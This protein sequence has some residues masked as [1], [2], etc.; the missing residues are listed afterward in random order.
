MGGKKQINVRINVFGLLLISLC[1]TAD[2]F[3]SLLM[4]GKKRKELKITYASA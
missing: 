3:L 1:F 4:S 2:L